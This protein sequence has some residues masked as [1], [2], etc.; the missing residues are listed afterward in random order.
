MDLGQYI[1]LVAI[2]AAVALLLAP[3]YLDNQRKVAGKRRK[4]RGSASSKTKLAWVV[5]HRTGIKV[6]VEIVK[7]GALGY[8]VYLGYW[9][10]QAFKWFVTTLLG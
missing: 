8:L 2:I 4:L 1:F 10:V 9:F 5:R 7:I 3:D 6:A